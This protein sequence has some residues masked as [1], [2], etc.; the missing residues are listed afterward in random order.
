MNNQWWYTSNE[1][2]HGPVDGAELRRSAKEGLLK[3]T[4]LVWKPGMKNWVQA[5]K[6]KGLAF[7]EP[8]P[9]P[10]SPFRADTHIEFDS[11]ESNALSHTQIFI[12]AVGV[13]YAFLFVVD[14]FCVVWLNLYGFEEFSITNEPLRAIAGILFGPLILMAFIFAYLLPSLVAFI[15]NHRNFLAIAVLQILLGWTGVV[16]LIALVWAFTKDV[17]SRERGIG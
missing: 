5:A 6:V 10:R 3:P 2:K 16:W 17:E 4:D 7:I 8:P 1:V 12:R 14:L 9:I 13:L 15:R 11:T